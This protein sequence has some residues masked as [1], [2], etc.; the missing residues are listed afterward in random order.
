MNKFDTPFSHVSIMFPCTAQFL[1]QT[2]CTHCGVELASTTF[3]NSDY[4]I[5]TR[6]SD[7]AITCREV[8][9]WIA[10]MSGNFAR[11][12]MGAIGVKM[13]RFWGI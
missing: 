13:V 12:N 6:P 7:E 2:T 11:C 9:S 4:V 8:I 5:T 10:Q 3:L 1:L